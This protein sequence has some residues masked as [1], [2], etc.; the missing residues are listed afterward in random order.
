MFS[1]SEVP[2]GA[3]CTVAPSSVTL[4]GTNPASTK[5]MVMTTQRSGLFTWL[6]M[7]IQTRIGPRRVEVLL[8]VY[9]LF[10]FGFLR[11]HKVKGRTLRLLLPC[12]AILL[13]ALCAPCGGGG[14]NVTLLPARV[15][16]GGTPAGTYTIV[17]T[18]TSGNVSHASSTQ[19]TVN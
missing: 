18:G 19:L 5:L 2:A 12:S 6:R 15:H 17:V 14:G 16:P 4:D 13:A 7:R 1:C 11:L 10:C 8:L 3:C 9:I